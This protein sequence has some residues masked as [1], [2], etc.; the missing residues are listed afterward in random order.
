MGVSSA[1]AV[2]AV[3]SSTWVGED[4]ARVSAFVCDGVSTIW[5]LVTWSVDNCS[6]SPLAKRF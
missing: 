2:S 6:A 1:I 5:S 3:A 4:S